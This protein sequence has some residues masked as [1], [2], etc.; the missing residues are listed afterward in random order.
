MSGELFREGRSL[1]ACGI[2]GLEKLLIE[3]VL[4]FELERG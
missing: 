4:E 3:V 1:L 2:V